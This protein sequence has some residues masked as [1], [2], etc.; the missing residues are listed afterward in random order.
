M[1]LLSDKPVLSTDCSRTPGLK[2]SLN[3]VHLKIHHALKGTSYPTDQCSVTGSAAIATTI[4]NYLFAPTIT[5]PAD[6]SV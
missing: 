3:Q 2:S 1:F 5:P 4:G 6:P